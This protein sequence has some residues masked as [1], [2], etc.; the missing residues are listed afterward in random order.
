MS[1]LDAYRK[2]HDALSDMIEE[3]TIEGANIPE[4]VEILATIPRTLEGYRYADVSTGHITADDNKRLAELALDEIHA[5]P[6][7]TNPVTIAAYHGG[8]FISI[9]GEP[10]LIDDDFIRKMGVS[11]ALIDLIRRCQAEGFF[12]LRLDRDAYVQDLP[13]FEW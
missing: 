11:T 3:G 6:R 5:A 4:L 9:P 10:E 13:K 7:F 12:V 8:Y 2:L 1:E